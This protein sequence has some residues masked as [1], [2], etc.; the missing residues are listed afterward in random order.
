M[1]L[2]VNHYP[3]PV[4]IV[5]GSGIIQHANAAACR[6]TGY[7]QEEL[8]GLMVEALVPP[9]LRDAH[10][11][12]RQHMMAEYRST[13]HK[14]SMALAIFTKSGEEIPVEISIRTL[15][16]D[17]EDVAV[18][19]IREVGE[20]KQTEYTLMLANGVFNHSA[21]AILVTGPDR[22]IL[23]VNPAFEAI[24]QY[25]ESEVLNRQPDELIKSDRHSDEDYQ[26]LWEV[27]SKTDLWKGELCDKR[28]DGSTFSAQ[29]TISAVRDSTGQITHYIDL[30]RDIS[31]KKQQ[32]EYIRNLAHYDQLTGL[33]NRALFIDRLKQ[34]IYRAR[35]KHQN[36]GLMFIDLD[37]FKYVNDT[38]G[39]DAG[40]ELLAKVAERLNETVREQDTVSRLGGDEF[41]IILEELAAPEDSVLVADKLIQ[42]LCQP[43]DIKGH[44][45]VVGASVGI[46]TFPLHGD[47]Q[48]TLIK[49][50]DTA[51]YHAKESG[52]NQSKLY[53]E[54]MS[55]KA[56]E[57]FHLER[58]LRKAIEDEEFELYFQPQINI[59]SGRVCG[60]E[61]LIRWNNP[62]QGLIG[63]MEFIP[64]AE[65][66]GLIIPLGEWVLH[67]S[68][69]CANR[70]QE[71]GV[72][73]IT[74]SVNVS[75][76]QLSAGNFAEK[77]RQLVT[78]N[79]FPPERLELEITES[80]VME[81]PNQVIA[82]LNQ[83]REL[84]VN[85]S[86]DDFG[87]G[88]S[89]L[90][91]LK[92]LPVTKVKIDRS[93]VRDI[94]VDKDDEEI[95]KAIIAMSRTLGLKVIAEGAETKDHIDFIRRADCHDVQGYY[96][97]QP[98]PEA[99]FIRFI[100]EFNKRPP[101]QTLPPTA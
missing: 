71:Q 6:F 84:G 68:L 29:H 70:W 40:D 65:E 59:T 37:R 17:G 47:D 38:L 55:A 100:T 56:S 46:S 3:D 52:R 28:K 16:L 79:A 43:L 80:A 10:G 32:E 54:S 86:L 50:A 22:R 63:P 11:R 57:R 1:N 91:Y 18:L 13:S 61:T 76:K 44:E 49:C 33:P 14:R 21:E 69:V 53:N 39:H 42:H 78:L 30:F 35:R 23:R 90:S 4:M 77:V 45:M 92:K 97:S 5:D 12:H 48:D 99:D 83:I 7:T 15:P 101:E 31:E 41:T 85:I 82:E 25:Q 20:P 51:M 66:T 88:Y 72:E 27:L 64:L 93:F 9:A 87:T 89:S 36:I 81:N 73:D 60:C 62:E 96:Y 19:A 24:T 98:L 95:V 67:H 58:L 8:I 2:D 26:Q 75:S 74:V 34:S 94:N